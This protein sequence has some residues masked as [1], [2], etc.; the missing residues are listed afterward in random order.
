MTDTPHTPAVLVV[1]ESGHPARLGE[2]CESLTLHVRDTVTFSTSVTDISVIIIISHRIGP[3]CTQVG[4]SC[5]LLGVIWQAS[6]I[7]TVRLRGC[8]LSDAGM[9]RL[10]PLLLACPHLSLIDLG[11][12]AL[13]AEAGSFFSALLVHPATALVDLCVANNRLDNAGITAVATALHANS[14]LRRLDVSATRIGDPSVLAL[15]DALSV[16]LDAVFA[17]GDVMLLLT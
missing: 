7:T 6:T 4:V 12:N 17:R 16:R 13:T 10:V 5:S 15:A 3:H 8:G 14:T 9:A 11:D 1:D 2:L